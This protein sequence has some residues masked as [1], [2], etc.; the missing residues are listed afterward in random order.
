MVVIC[1]ADDMLQKCT[2]TSVNAGSADE[3]NLSQEALSSR[4]RELAI[5]VILQVRAG[6]R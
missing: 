5:F 3:Q 4:N 2:S 6:K 1:F